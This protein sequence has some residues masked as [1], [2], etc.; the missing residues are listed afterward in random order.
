M[1][2]NLS[3]FL[4]ILNSFDTGVVDFATLHLMFCMVDEVKIWYIMNV[5]KTCYWLIAVWILEQLLTN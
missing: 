2:S 1:K 5:D 3:L 4:N